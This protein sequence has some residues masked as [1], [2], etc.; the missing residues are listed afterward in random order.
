VEA[1]RERHPDIAVAA[2]VLATSE[3]VGAVGAGNID[4]GIARAP[5]EAAGV[6]LRLI[7]REPQGALVP[8]SHPLA[9]HDEVAL[10]E[11]AA[12]PLLM[13][14]REDNPARYDLVMGAFREAGLSPRLVE[15]RVAFDPTM[16]MIRD[17]SAIA[18]AGTSFAVGLADDLRWVPLAEPAL[19]L[20][21]QLV[22]R[23]GEPSP[24]ADR[25]E[26]VAVA[27]AAAAGWL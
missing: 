24:L 2:G 4:A 19:R 16:R 12:H 10:A 26:R 9:A 25:F 17:G 21:V 27:A 7:R 22:L 15:R 13:H 5:I 18:L 11:V 1:L 23:E 8:A 14:P 3:I 20:P 6:R